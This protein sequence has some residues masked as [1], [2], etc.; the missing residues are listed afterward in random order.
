M[1]T[2]VIVGAQW[3]DEGK[4]RIVDLLSERAHMVVRCQ[5]GANAGHTVVVGDQQ[6]ILHLV[7]AGVIHPHT[8]C[9]IGNG[10]ALDIPALFSELDMLAERGVGIEGRLFVSD[11]AHVTLPYHRLLDS[12]RAPQEGGRRL[13][14][15]NRGIR[16]TY[17]DKVARLGIRVCDLLDEE[18]LRE[19]LRTNLREKTP[20]LHFLPAEELPTEEALFAECREWA[21]RLAPYVANTVTLV[22]RAI[23][24]GQNVL[25]EG[26]QGTALDVDFGTYPFVTSSN[27]TA[28]G[29]C[30]GS[31]VG[32][33][34]IDRVI[35]LAKAYCTRVGDERPFPS[36][37]ED[38]MDERIRRQGGEFGATT[39]RPRRCGWFDA[40]L[41]RHTAAVNGMDSM[42]VSKLDVL[43][44][45]ETVK[46]CV[47]YRV[48]DRVL[49]EFPADLRSL[50]SAEP[51]Y[52][53]LEGW[54]ER[55]TGARSYLTLPAKA[56]KYLD[57]LA[58]LSG[59][60]ICIVSVG[61]R[62]EDAVIIDTGLPQ[63]Q[64]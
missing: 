43:D 19:Q 21:A 17:V 64:F 26:A 18:R 55:S 33:S 44:G 28:A 5:G 54:S 20:G 47:G 61:P 36:L 2:L 49:D 6:F 59:V 39:G 46:I 30:T 38:E 23:N 29:A 51:V 41:L 50:D 62:R 32:P 58:L 35:G 24:A 25:F 27:T 40:V 34:K 45:L 12:P 22:N 52:E 1:P 11:R 3:G 60:P 48:G 9:V 53:E 7:P 14:T 42:V 8:V 63:Y 4:G 15:T 37:M 13:V 16:P 56:R 31:G 57:R 10:V